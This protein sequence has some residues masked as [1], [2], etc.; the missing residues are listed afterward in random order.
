MVRNQIFVDIEP[1]S[2]PPRN[3]KKSSHES[4]V[5][6]WTM[7]SEELKRLS[8]PAQSHIYLKSK[9]MTTLVLY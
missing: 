1:N 8:E 4:V 7:T 5:K 9:R 2:P 6:V 3:N